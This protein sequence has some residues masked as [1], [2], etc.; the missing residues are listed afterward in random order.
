MKIQAI[1]IAAAIAILLGVVQCFF[2]TYCWS[3][4]AS[5]SPLIP[6]LVDLGLRG[7]GIRAAAWSI[8]FM[9]NIALSIPMAFALV[10]LRPKKL[11]LYLVLA[12][13][14]AFIWSNMG[15]VGNPYFGQFAG[16]FV[17]AWIPQLLALPIAAWLVSLTLNRGTPDHSSKSKSIL[18]ST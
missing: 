3:Y 17:L 14:S 12:V 13:V 9:I 10:K 1:Q 7:Q 2:V 8:D 16:T 6:W 4:I 5:H 18:G 11:G 15:L